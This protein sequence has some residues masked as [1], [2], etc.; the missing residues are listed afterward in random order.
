M[1]A[2]EIIVKISTENLLGEAL[3]ETVQKLF[4]EYGVRIDGVDFEWVDVLGAS[5]TSAIVRQAK[6]KTTITK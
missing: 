1:A 2:S 4:N 5:K 6:L 3:L